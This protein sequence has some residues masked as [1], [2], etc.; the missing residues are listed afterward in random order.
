MFDDDRSAE[1]VTM[2]LS[3]FL[4]ATSTHESTYVAFHTQFCNFCVKVYALNPLL[5]VWP[6]FS[7]GFIVSSSSASG[8]AFFMFGGVRAMGWNSRDWLWKYRGSQRGDS[9]S[10]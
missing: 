10:G 6:N 4:E 5:R 7:M 1:S 3:Q 9:K 8:I 2:Y